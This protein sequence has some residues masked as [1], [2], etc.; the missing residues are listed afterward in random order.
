MKG[1]QESQIFARQN[2]SFRVCVSLCE[3]GEYVTCNF[4]Y[5]FHFLGVFFSMMFFCHLH[6]TLF[7]IS[8][9]MF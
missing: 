5:V 2:I 6:C 3:L 4:G 7:L 9:S 8:F 1:L